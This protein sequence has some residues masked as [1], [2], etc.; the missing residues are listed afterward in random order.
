MNADIK[1]I[2]KALLR[3]GRLHLSHHFDKLSLE[4][5]N[6][7]AEYCGINH[8]FREDI[9]LCDIFNIEEFE[10]PLKKQER[11]LGFGNF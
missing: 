6:R 3:K 11:A 2:D 7:L 5:A 4:D 10:S 8:T 1:A 9:A